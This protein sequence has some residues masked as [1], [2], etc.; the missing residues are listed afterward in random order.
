MCGHG[1]EGRG[2]LDRVVLSMFPS[3]RKTE[4]AGSCCVAQ[5]A[6]LGSLMRRG[7]DAGGRAGT[8]Q[9]CTAITSQSKTC[10]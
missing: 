8:T 3:M 6:A 4:G 10:P 5:G 9:H 2:G 1:S 7:W